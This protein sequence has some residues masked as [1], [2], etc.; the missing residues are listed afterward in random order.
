[1]PPEKRR[2]L[3]LA[4][5]LLAN[6]CQGVSY[7][8]S[9]F[10]IP[11]GE[12]MNL[13]GEATKT[14]L[15]FAQSLTWALLPVGMLLAGRLADKGFGRFTVLAGAALFGGGLLLAGGATSIQGLWLTYGA[16]TSLG[17]G[18]AYGT[19][20][21][22]SVRWFPDRRGLASGLS[23]AALG[24]GGLIIAP[25]AQWLVVNHGV[26]T[27]FHALGAAAFGLMA[28]AAWFVVNPPAGWIPPALAAAPA[29]VSQTTDT[30]AA[31]PA[32]RAERADTWRD[33]LVNPRFYGL[34]LLYVCGVFTGLLIFPRCRQLVEE[35]GYSVAMAVGAVMWLTMANSAGRLLWGAVS[36]GIGRWP[37]MAAMLSLT[38]LGLSG[39]YFAHSANTSAQ[40]PP[41]VIDGCILTETDNEGA[42]VEEKLREAFPPER[43]DAGILPPA[44]AAT[45]TGSRGADGQ[46]AL[47]LASIV[48][49]GL[50]FGGILGTFPALCAESFGTAN[51][52]VN[53]GVL[54]TAF[55]A[56]G[57][58]APQVGV[59]LS[60]A[61]ALGL[62]A[63]LAA[64]GLAL[65]AI[66]S[67]RKNAA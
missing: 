12:H 54:F 6:M 61:G 33:M 8:Y 25:L 9:V 23:V 19:I 41:V 59:H 7:T 17:S 40:T 30:A 60:L 1:M 49:V 65:I 31:S 38:I 64:V 53:Y 20:V 5:G 55:S 22:A 15:A 36:D 29:S 67:K 26:Q 50:C 58:I 47:L 43:P 48:V 44:P 45:I 57:L 42:V 32:K 27:M 62:S 37:A 11:L 2:W 3:I 4:A 51:A 52:A 18:M 24:A 28:L 13:V 56:A 14:Q 21:G 35:P 46:L 39:L 16:M 34:W 10:A 66:L 63:A